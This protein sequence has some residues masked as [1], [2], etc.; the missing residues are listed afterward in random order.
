MMTFSL[1][2]LGHFTKYSYASDSG[3]DAAGRS[4]LAQPG[5]PRASRPRGG[6]AGNR[7]SRPGSSAARTRSAV[8]EHGHDANSR[9]D[10]ERDEGADHPAVDAADAAGER[11]LFA[12]MPTK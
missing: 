10:P 4:P 1:R 2:S 11:Q 12:S 5:A 8:G 7:R 6:A 3:V 9:V